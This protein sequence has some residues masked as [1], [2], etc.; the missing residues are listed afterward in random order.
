M[1]E[2]K[3]VQF[4]LKNSTTREVS[5][6]L[7]NASSI[8]PITNETQFEAGAVNTLSPFN[9]PTNGF[10]NPLTNETV[11][12]NSKD[13]IGVVN[14]E[15]STM[16]V[17]LNED[18]LLLND[19]VAMVLN[20]TNNYL[21]TGNNKDSDTLTNVLVLD[22]ITYAQITE[23]TIPNPTITTIKIMDISYSPVNNY[24][25]VNIIEGGAL[26]YIIYID[27]ATNTIAGTIPLS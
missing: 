21:Y 5:I 12:F 20:T 15:T 22:A 13:G 9:A 17:Y 8:T 7:F 18:T 4:N 26:S 24:V 23:I 10:Y 3:K 1:Q 6:D 25:Y 27:C 11:L 2:P 19:I 14:Q 16:S